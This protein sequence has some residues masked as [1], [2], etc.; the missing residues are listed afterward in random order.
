MLFPTYQAVVASVGGRRQALRVF[1]RWLLL[2]GALASLDHAPVRAQEDGAARAADREQPRVERRILVLRADHSPPTKTRMRVDRVLGQ[3][4]AELGMVVRVSALPFRDAQ[5]ALGCSGSLSECGGSVAAALQSEQLAVISLEQRDATAHLELYL[6]APGEERAD[7]AELSLASSSA[8]ESRVRDLAHRV[9]G[10][11]VPE[12]R[13]A[14][15]EPRAAE[16]TPVPAP[17]PQA[18]LRAPPSKR[19]PATAPAAERPGNL[20]LRAVGWS[21]ATVGGA[22]LLGALATSLAAHKASDRYAEREIRNREDA[23]R[24][25]ASYARAEHQARAS[26]VLFGTSG[27]VLLAAAALLVWERLLPNRQDRMLAV[28]ASPVAHGTLLFVSGRLEGRRW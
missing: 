16:P 4:L 11:M 12:A 27:A 1:V 9:Y 13:H 23:D 22:L 21:A 15:Q 3:A 10:E 7:S 2:A 20:P 26:R 24:A 17:V 18:S 25:L 5:L 19:I 8:L 6:F 14:L 28:S